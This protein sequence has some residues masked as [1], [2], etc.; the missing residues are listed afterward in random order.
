MKQAIVAVASE[1][2][3]LEDPLSAKKGY[4]CDFFNLKVLRNVTKES[5]EGFV[6]ESIDP[7]SILFTNKHTT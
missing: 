7:K 2:S 3:T 1:S 4:H 6:K 5:M